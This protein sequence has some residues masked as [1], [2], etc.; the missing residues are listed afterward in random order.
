[1]VPGSVGAAAVADHD[2]PALDAVA[3]TF[4]SLQMF[5]HAAEAARGATEMHIEKGLRMA[6]L[7]SRSACSEYE[8]AAQGQ[9]LAGRRAESRIATLTHRESEIAHLAAKGLSNRQ[10][11]S[12]LFLSVRTVESHLYQARAKLGAASRRDLAAIFD[13]SD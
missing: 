5:V 1:V 2:G 6:A 4:A 3:S 11:A 7:A 10:I 9:L 12:T 8:A 13:V